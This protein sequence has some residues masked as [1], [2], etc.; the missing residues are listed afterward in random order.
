MNRRSMSIFTRWYSKLYF[1]QYLNDIDGR[2]VDLFDASD[3]CHPL[4]ITSKKNFVYISQFHWQTYRYS[5]WIHLLFAYMYV[6]FL[7][8]ET[9]LN[10]NFTLLRFFFCYWLFFCWYLLI[11]H[12]SFIC[13]I[14]TDAEFHPFHGNKFSFVALSASP[15][16]FVGYSFIYFKNLF[17]L[18]IFL[19]LLHDIELWTVVCNA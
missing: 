5:F 14:F 10:V 1:H 7:S 17:P 16:A 19:Y 4:D 11:L 12:L 13:S 6:I 8:C 18:R 3:I 2:K 9:H 15:A